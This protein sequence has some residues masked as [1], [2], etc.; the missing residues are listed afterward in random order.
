MTF[1]CKEEFL[2]LEQLAKRQVRIYND[3]CDMGT[4]LTTQQV[5]EL[6][7]AVKE[8]KMFYGGTNW[9]CNAGRMKQG[10]VNGIKIPFEIEGD[11]V[12]GVSIDVN[13]VQE[14]GK[15]YASIYISRMNLP[16]N[17]VPCFNRGEE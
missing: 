16:K 7:A 12:L 11:T 17:K 1:P 6:R 8:L 2:Q 10:A 14:K 3:S 13:V 4:Y 5:N 15:T 9:T